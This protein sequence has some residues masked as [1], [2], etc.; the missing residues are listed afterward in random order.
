[1]QLRTLLAIAGL[2]I[3]ATA[4]GS[5]SKDTTGPGDGNNPP[6]GT[7]YSASI[8]GGVTRQLTGVA[9]FATDDEDP[10]FGFGMAMATTNSQEGIILWRETAGLLG[11]GQHTVANSFEAESEDDVPANHLVVETYLNTGGEV[12]LYCLATGGTVN[13]TSA[14][15]TRLRGNFQFTAACVDLATEEVKEITVNGNFDAISGP[16]NLPD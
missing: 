12:P 4:C 1:M 2:T 10:D 3:A 8:T 7:S 11:V 5:D 16:I 6:G 13:V 15:G 14:S 9:G